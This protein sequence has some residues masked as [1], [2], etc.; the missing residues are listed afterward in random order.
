MGKNIDYMMELVNEYLSGKTP[1]YIFELDFQT[2][3]LARYKK[4]VRED[5]NYAE[6][7]YDLLSEDGVDAGDGLSD[8]RF[9]Q[10][11]RRQYNKVKSVADDGFR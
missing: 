2:E 1:R 8:T 6:Y 4:M 5:R 7:F 9:K 3:I 10:L 11:I